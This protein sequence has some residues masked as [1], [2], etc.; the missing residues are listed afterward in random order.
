MSLIEPG[1]H[2]EFII[3]PKSGSNLDIESIRRLAGHLRDGGCSVG[4]SLT[5]SLGHAGELA[6][7]AAAKSCTAIITAG[8]DG[9]VRAVIEAMAGSATPL[10]IIPAGTENL[11][12]TEMGIDTSFDALLALLE[13]PTLKT[14]DLGLANGSHFMA[15]LGVGFDAEVIHRMNLFRAGHITH[16]DYIWPIFRTFWEHRF[17]IIRVEIDG[18]VICDEPA[19]VFVSNISRYSVGLGISPG[20]DCGDG[21]LDVTIYRCRTQARLLKHALL[22]A[23]QRAD[24]SRFVARYRC[25]EATISSPDPNT[26]VQIDGDPGPRLP[27]D[28]RIVPAAAH[29]LRPAEG[30]GR[31]SR[32]H[33]LRRWIMR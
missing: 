29:I 19:M 16:F 2:L 20:A 5:K 7:G 15:V 33:Y 10:L 28:V 1:R 18:E 21:L 11:L 32:Y 8:G 17:P 24:S 3:N 30:S 13:K 22:T 23:M 12:A 9:T 31:I 14:L 6:A 4:V 26:H 25:R 27:I